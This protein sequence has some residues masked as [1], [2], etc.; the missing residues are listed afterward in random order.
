MNKIFNLTAAQRKEWFVYFLP[1]VKGLKHRFV[2]RKA[3]EVDKKATLVLQLYNEQDEILRK[4]VKD[5]LIT[6]QGSMYMNDKGEFRR[7]S[8]TTYSQTIRNT[9]CKEVNDNIQKYRTKIT[10]LGLMKGDNALHDKITGY[11]DAVKNFSASC[12]AWASTI[13][14]IDADNESLLEM[15]TFVESN[16]TKMKSA[17]ESMRLLI[18]TYKKRNGLK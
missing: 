9:H 8:W 3:A 12:A 15:I 2:N 16:S 6:L 14:S 11:L 10:A 7:S 5:L 1:A 13:S 17:D 4:S 18:D